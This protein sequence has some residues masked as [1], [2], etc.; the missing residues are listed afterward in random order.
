MFISYAGGYNQASRYENLEFSKEVWD[1]KNVGVFGI[2]KDY[3]SQRAW[4]KQTLFNKN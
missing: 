1:N 2:W 3:E 4:K